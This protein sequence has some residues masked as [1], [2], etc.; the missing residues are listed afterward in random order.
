MRIGN[1]HYTV[2]W[3]HLLV[4]TVIA[5]IC[6][7]YL[8]D[9]LATSTHVNNILFVLPAVIIALMLCFAILPQIVR[10]AD[11]DKGTSNKQTRLDVKPGEQATTQS[12]SELGWIALLIVCFGAYVYL[13]DRIGFDVASWLFI[14][15][16]LFI[17][18]ERRLLSLVIYP[19]IATTLIVVGFNA[20]IPYPMYTLIF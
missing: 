12:W 19:P 1:N 9:T 20:L 18:G 8:R 4:V 10:R 17:C 3:G 11:P 2:D 13:L 16:G 7:A 14:T 6:A 5:V 15:L